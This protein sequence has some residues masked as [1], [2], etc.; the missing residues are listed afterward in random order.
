MEPAGPELWQCQLVIGREL[1]VTTALE[2]FA[3]AATY[4]LDRHLEDGWAIAGEA[5]ITADED[6]ARN[7]TRYRLTVPIRRMG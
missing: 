5:T 3:R 7:Q 4:R 6:F 1:P 2:E